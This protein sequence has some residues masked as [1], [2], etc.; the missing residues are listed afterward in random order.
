[1]CSCEQ[2][3]IIPVVHLYYRCSPAFDF[4]YNTLYE[5]KNQRVPSS[6]DNKN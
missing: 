6:G 1:M 5:A 3:K 4:S 2:R